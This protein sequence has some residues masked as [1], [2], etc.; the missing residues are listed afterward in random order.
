MSIG[1]QVPKSAAESGK[2]VEEQSAKNKTGGGRSMSLANVLSAISVN[3]PADTKNLT[4]HGIACDSRKVSLGYLFFALHGVK[5]DG[6]KFVRDAIERGAVAVA[7]EI[8]APADWPA[9]APW[10]Q[11]P[12][13]RKGLAIAAANFFCNPANALKMIAVTCTN[14]K[15]TTTSLIDSVLRA[16]GAK[17]GL[18]CPNPYPTPLGEY[19]APNTTPESLDLQGFFA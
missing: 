2:V 12:E 13:S 9:S 1:L 10:I 18:F 6:T 7:S 11:L 8:A 15:T 3:L 17:T 4:I 5:E 14:G 19:P 16:Y